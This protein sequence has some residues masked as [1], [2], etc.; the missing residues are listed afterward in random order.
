MQLGI[1]PLP[2]ALPLRLL[3]IRIFPKAN[4]SLTAE[5]IIMQAN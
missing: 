4:L 3:H 1:S 5:R 2:G